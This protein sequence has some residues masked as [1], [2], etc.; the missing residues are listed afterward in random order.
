MGYFKVNHENLKLKL[1]ESF[2]DRTYINNE[3]TGYSKKELKEKIEL[4]K[5][6]IKNKEHKSKY[7][8]KNTYK[9][10]FISAY[11][12]FI[13]DDYKNALQLFSKALEK[14]KK[15]DYDI[16][17][18]MYECLKNIGDIKTAKIFYSK[19]FNIFKEKQI[20]HTTTKES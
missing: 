13:H 7:I 12:Y 15:L 4:F 3:Y 1:R 16:Y 6:K 9:Y 19:F 14:E 18:Y 8:K 5:E 17:F 2:E 10:F 20:K 11:T